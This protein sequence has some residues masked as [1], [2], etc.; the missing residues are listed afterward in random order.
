MTHLNIF[1]NFEKKPT[2]LK[3]DPF[4]NVVS[5][6]HEIKIVFFKGTGDIEMAGIQ[7]TLGIQET[8]GTPGTLGS[9]GIQGTPGIQGTLGTPEIQGTLGIP[10]T[11]GTPGTLETVRSQGISVAT[12]EQVLR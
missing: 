8:L 12:G 3:E 6:N 5:F 2:I 11:L 10:G 4:S 9:Q 7:G 1:S